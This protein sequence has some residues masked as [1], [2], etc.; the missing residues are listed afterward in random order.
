MDIVEQAVKV[1]QRDGIIVYPTETVY[2]LGGDALSE[3]AVLR[4]Y[5]VKQRP[6]SQP[7]SVAVSDVDMLWAIAHIDDDAEAF[8]RRFLPG[9]VTV[10]LPATSCIP[11]MLTGGTGLIGVRMP[12]HE[13]ALSIIAELDAPITATSAN[14]TG[15]RAPLRPDEVTVVYDLMVD[16]GILPGTP[17]TV[18]D[19]VH[20]KIIRPGALVDDVARF[21][22]ALDS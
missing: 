11:A 14:I 21:L 19:L 8:V 16:G 5:T 3:E 18:V 1:L 13:I 20:R 15:K 17:S 22:S 4:V 12:D 7:M 10:V 9:A 2:G 6:L